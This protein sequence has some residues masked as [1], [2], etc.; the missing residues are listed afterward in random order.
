M[1]RGDTLRDDAASD[2]TKITV[3][4]R[5]KKKVDTTLELK[6]PTHSTKEE[7]IVVQKTKQETGHWYY[8]SWVLVTLAMIVWTRLDTIRIT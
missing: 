2:D 6:K 5:E 1:A 8:L 4:M 3:I 7:D